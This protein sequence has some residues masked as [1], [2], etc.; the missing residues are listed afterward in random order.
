MTTITVIKIIVDKLWAVVVGFLFPKTCVGCGCA[1]TWFC[2]R[3]RQRLKYAAA[4]SCPVCGRAAI[5]GFT[6]PG[7]ETRYTLDRLLTPF[8]YEEPLRSAI[9]RGKY[10]GEW[11]LFS[12]LADMVCLWF[13]YRGIDFLPGAILL[14]IPLHP[15]RSWERG[16]NQAEILASCLA[17][18]MG[19]EMNTSWL[20]RTRYTQSQTQLDKEERKDNVRGA[21]SASSAV[22]KNNLI[23]VDDVCASGFTLGE[24]ARELKK[25]GARTVWAV[26]VARGAN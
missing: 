16:F 21:F 26:T 13:E 23:L 11:D 15:I 9:H 1:G 12:S 4:Q 22:A 14:P 20:R 6:H 18:N 5:G 2:P 7:C 24:A 25:A 3:C 10:R 17:E 8:K 19:L